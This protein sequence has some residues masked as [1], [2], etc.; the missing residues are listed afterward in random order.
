MSQLDTWQGEFGNQYTDRNTIDWH[1][2]LPAFQRILSGLP[3]KRVLEVGCNR[4]HNLL[5]ISKLLGEASEVIG[6]EPNA[7]AAKLAR[8]LD[9]NI[10]VIRGDAYAIPFVSGYFDLAFTA[11]VLIHVPDERL[12][13][14]IRE[15]ARVTRKYVLAIEYFSEHD[16]EIA[17]RNNHELLWKR[18]FLRHYQE[19][20][21]NL[22][23]VNSGYLDS[24]EGFDRCHWWLL[25][26]RSPETR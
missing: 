4:G 14:A 25:E 23:L 5:C 17:Y 10:S 19:S 21:P 16:T 3:L 12:G 11:G 15:I 8:S 1:K 20:L 7:Y 26:K 2:R 13:E 24:T 22:S 18:D 9:P 6:V